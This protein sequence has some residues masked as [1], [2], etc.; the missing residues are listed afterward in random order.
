MGWR[1]MGL[2]IG[3]SVKIDF[4]YGSYFFFGITIITGGRYAVHLKVGRGLVRES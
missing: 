2:L 4:S 1:N 3:P